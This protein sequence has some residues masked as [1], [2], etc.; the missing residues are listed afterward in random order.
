MDKMKST[1]TRRPLKGPL[2]EPLWPLT[3]GI[4]GML[5]GSW[6]SSNRKPSDAERAVVDS[7]ATKRIAVRTK[8]R[9]HQSDVARSVQVLA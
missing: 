2:T 7:A 1:D 5:K 8:Y 9:A 6:G 4:Y 3:V